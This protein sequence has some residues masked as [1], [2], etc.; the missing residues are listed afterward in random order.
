MKKID[1]P[2]R[3]EVLGKSSYREEG[4]FQGGKG[5][6][7]KGLCTSQGPGEEQKNSEETAKVD[8]VR[9]RQRKVEGGDIV[10]AGAN[11]IEQAQSIID[12]GAWGS[13]GKTGGAQAEKKGG[14][15]PDFRR[16]DVVRAR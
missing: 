16:A 15:A 5:L 10:I 4:S 9:S 1:P 7:T 2:K 12:G 8:L 13:A 3:P 14:R 11:M 6:R